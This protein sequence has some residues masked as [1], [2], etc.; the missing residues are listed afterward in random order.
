M[1]ALKS[2]QLCSLWRK[3]ASA[4]ANS[5]TLHNFAQNQFVPGQTLLKKNRVLSCWERRHYI[6]YLVLTSVTKCRTFYVPFSFTILKYIIFIIFKITFKQLES[7]L[8]C[9]KK[10]NFNP[11]MLKHPQPLFGKYGLEKGHGKGLCCERPERE[12]R[13]ASEGFCSIF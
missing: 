9:V 5:A 11:K 1:Q 10:E 2:R 12:S 3:A 4:N 13:K 6:I 8:P 7:S